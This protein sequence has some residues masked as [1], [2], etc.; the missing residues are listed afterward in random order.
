MPTS[1]TNYNLTK[2]GYE[3]FY[4]VGVPNANMDKIDAALK[5]L[6]DA[7]G[8]IDLTTLSHAI[9]AVD[10]KVTAHLEEIMPHKF[11]DNGKWY[12]WGFRTVDGEPEFIYEEVL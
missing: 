10:N 5:A 7:L 9:T 8:G 12:R 11:F 2:P 6:S 4:D 1:T 3:E